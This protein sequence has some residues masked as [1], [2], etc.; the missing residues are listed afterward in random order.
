MHI[1]Q[2]ELSEINLGRHLSGIPKL[3]VLSTDTSLGTFITY[4][5]QCWNLL[6]QRKSYQAFVC[7]ENKRTFK[8]GLDICVDS[9]YSGYLR[10][11]T[12]WVERYAIVYCT[13]ASDMVYTGNF[14]SMLRPACARISA[15]IAS[16]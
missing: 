5:R 15:E 6:M 10:K 3:D 12:L 8:Q 13:C 11:R 4:T 2:L 9:I 14:Q 16:V 1:T 7:A